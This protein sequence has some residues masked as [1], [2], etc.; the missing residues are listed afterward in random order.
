[1][2]RR[3][4]LTSRWNCLRMGTGEGLHRVGKGL[5]VP[6]GSVRKGFPFTVVV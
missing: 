6:L 2:R 3:F 5:D 1:M 4:V